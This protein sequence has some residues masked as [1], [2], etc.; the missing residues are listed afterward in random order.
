MLHALLDVMDVVVDHRQGDAHGQNGDD[1]EGHGRVGHKAVGLQIVGNR[2][3][4]G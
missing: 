4:V 1:R 3:M 2:S